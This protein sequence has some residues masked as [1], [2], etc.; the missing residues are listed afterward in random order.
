MLLS[1]DPA[2]DLATSPHGAGRTQGLEQPELL[3]PDLA[4]GSLALV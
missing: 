3:Q 1:P 4:L 2:T